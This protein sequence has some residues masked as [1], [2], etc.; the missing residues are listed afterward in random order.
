MGAGQGVQRLFCVTFGT[1]VGTA[2]IY[3]GEV[4]RGL[5]GHHPKVDI[6]PLILLAFMLLRDQRLLG[7]FGFWYCHW[8][9]WSKSRFRSPGVTYG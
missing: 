8:Q 1:G 2:F 3:N 4:Y 6:I 7:I 9:I 5:E